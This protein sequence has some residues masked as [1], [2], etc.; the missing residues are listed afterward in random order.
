[1]VRNNIGAVA[2]NTG[3]NRLTGLDCGDT[4]AQNRAIE[5]PGNLW[6]WL[7]ADAQRHDR[8]LGEEL[9][10]IIRE[11]FAARRQHIPLAE[12]WHAGRG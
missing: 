4:T 11:H 2:C 6:G 8:S 1:M 9:S 3:E 10:W 7:E 5:L 12:R